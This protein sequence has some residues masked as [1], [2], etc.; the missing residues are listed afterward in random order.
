MG[1]DDGVYIT[2]FGYPHLLLQVDISISFDVIG[3]F[4]DNIHVNVFFV[5]GN[6]PESGIVCCGGVKYVIF[7][8][9]IPGRDDLFVDDYVQIR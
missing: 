1:V 5:R 8:G 7:R 9:L 4:V 6:Q 3:I 2:I